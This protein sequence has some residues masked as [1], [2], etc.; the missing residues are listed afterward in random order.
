MFDEVD[1]GVG[2]QTA[3]AVGERLR[4]LGE[5]PPGALH[6]PP[7][8]DRGAGGQPLPDR[9]VGGGHNGAHHGRGPRGRRRGRGAGADAGRRRRRDGAA[10]GT[11]RSCWP[12]RERRGPRVPPRTRVHSDPQSVDA[13]TRPAT[14]FI[15][16]TGG[17]VSALGKGI[18]A[19][20]LGQLLVGSRALGHDPEVRPVHQRRPGHDEPVPARRGVRHRGRRRD[21]PRPGPLRALH[22]RQHQPRLER[23]RRARSTTRSSGASAAAT[24][25]AAP[26]R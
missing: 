21:R 26:S 13:R 1:A 8:A 7:A 23:H 16:V 9:E 3:R 2:G 11:P 5:A 22:G 6:H 18:A 10:R 20:S 15:F 24:T 14:R 17:V 4:A 19:A 25:W 12:P